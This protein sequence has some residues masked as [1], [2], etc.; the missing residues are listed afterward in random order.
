MGDET[1]KRT[2]SK[3][4][5]E[6]L[7]Q[8]GL[9]A[10]SCGEFFG[11]CDLQLVP[12]YI[13]TAGLQ[14]VGLDSLAQTEQRSVLEFCYPADQITLKEIFFPQVLRDGRNEI[15]SRFRHLKTGATFWVSYSAMVLKNDEGEPSGFGIII[16]NITALKLNEQ[17]QKFLLSLNDSL[18]PLSNSLEIQRTAM[19]VVGEYLQADRVLYAEF[20]PDGR[21]YYIPDNYV[22]AGVSKRVGRFPTNVFPSMIQWF[23]RGETLVINDVRQSPIL[24]DREKEASFAAGILALIGVPLIKGGRLV[25]QLV[26]EQ[27]RQREW[28]T[29][30]ISILQ[31]TAERIWA[32]VERATAENA[33]R[34]SEERM[35][36]AI[37][38]TRM[39]T[40]EWIPAEDRI[41]TS[42]SFVDLYGLPTLSGAQEGFALVVPEDKEVH[43]SKVQKIAA[44]GGSY[45]S[46]FRIKRRN[47]GHILWLEERAEAQLGSDGKVE[48]VI[49]VTLDITERK[50]AE[51]ALSESRE[52]LAHELEA[53]KQL[54]KISSLLI[55]D[56]GDGELYEQILNTAMAIMHAD[57]SS[58]QLLD[59]ECNE[60]RLLAW[61]NFHPESA[62]Y[63]QRVSIETGTT[64][65]SALRHGERI[66][67]QD[68]HTADFLKNS[69]S[70]KPF[71]LSGITSVQST[72]LTTREGRVVGMISTQWRSVHTPDER[73]LQLIDILARQAADFFERRRAVEAMR[74]SEEHLRCLNIELEE[75]VRSRTSELTATNAQLAAEVQERRAAEEQVKHLLKQLVAVQ[76]EERRKIAR[77]IHDH[78]GQQMTVLRINLETL[79]G[80]AQSHPE[81]DKRMH[82]TQQLA[83]EMDQSIDFLT[84]ELRPAALDTLG[85]PAA[86]SNLVQGWS[87]RFQ[88]SADFHCAGTDGLRLTPE[89]EINL[90]R[91]TQE[92][93]HNIY[94]HAQAN[95]VGVF[96]ER[97]DSKLLLIIEDNGCGFDA[98]DLSIINRGMGFVGMR[99]RAT[100]VGGETEI[101]SSPGEGTTIYVRVPLNQ[102]IGDEQ[103]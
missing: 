48:R 76:E 17:R 94:K 64:C 51:K 74:E 18:Q 33:L 39:V 30:E 69:E 7:Q 49:G 10:E 19:H 63:W 5:S 34:E 54:Q 4:H 87:E 46:D 81:L 16:R 14:M 70:L 85:L 73:E 93:M 58:I 92:A 88:I 22:R 96:L 25:A 82:R 97:R 43:I 21:E 27:S 80:A 31:E 28:T 61:R 83:E 38:T 40:W 65:G 50:R 2:S 52:K 1:T 53:T 72:P 66:I 8:L 47:D 99:E 42:D 77:N 57:F 75:R 24:S 56:E 35:Q 41:T 20:E 84:W 67:V 71:L 62:K 98:D 68:V 90:Y 9:L 59:T 29:D 12:F 91:L 100:L 95:N 89:T 23:S 6:I 60:L 102:G 45:D 13:N 101:E 55:E 103:S 86:L 78:L 44:E 79:V 32:A 15:E 37:R 3:A 11:L 36:L 26:V